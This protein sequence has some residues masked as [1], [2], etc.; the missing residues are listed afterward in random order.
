LGA[1]GTPA[2]EIS[3]SLSTRSGWRSAYA[4]ALCPPSYGVAC[5]H[6]ALDAHRLPIALR[7]ASSSSQK[8]LSASR[9]RC[10]GSAAIAYAGRLDSPH[11]VHV[12]GGVDT[13][14]DQ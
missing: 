2:G 6:H 4:K 13:T 8:K 7:Q 10:S 5:E 12:E 11:M 1:R 3:T 14:N 9:R